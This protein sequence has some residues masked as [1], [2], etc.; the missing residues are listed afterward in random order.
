MR[1]VFI[2]IL[3]LFCSGLFAQQDLTGTELTIEKA[4]VP[5]MH[6]I[7]LPNPTFILFEQSFYM[8]SITGGY[9][10]LI[11][12][13]HALRVEAGYFYPNLIGVISYAAHK[14]DPRYINHGPKAMFRYAVYPV[15]KQKGPAGFYFG[16]FA[17][18]SYIMSKNIDRQWA[19]D[20][21]ITS[22]I[23][24]Y[25]L[26]F[27]YGIPIDKILLDIS[28]S[29][30]YKYAKY[31]TVSENNYSAYKGSFQQDKYYKI[32]LL[33]SFNLGVLFDIPSKAQT[34]TE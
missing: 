19:P 26:S 28:V 17:Y 30:A 21:K 5:V 23:S 12:H 18:V 20:Y 6:I 3:T 29:G 8:E 1:G 9:E 31:Y 34:E 11:N 14:A 25:G 10:A 33:F 15:K 24:A 13:R 32:P 27:G 4:R 22:L 7:K 2:A 16:P